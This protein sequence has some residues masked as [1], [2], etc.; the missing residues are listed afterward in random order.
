M[1]TARILLLASAVAACS[2]TN[3][4]MRAQSCPELESLLPARAAADARA[5]AQRGDT[6]LLMIGGYVGTVPGARGISAPTRLV[7]GTG[8][9]QSAACQDLRPQA[10]KY[11]SIYNRTVAALSAK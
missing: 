1:R 4:K 3:G 10:E 8:D 6:R 7:E 9:D 2:P 5:A 11:A